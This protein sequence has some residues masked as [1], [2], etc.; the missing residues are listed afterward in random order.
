MN[1][2]QWGIAISLAVAVFFT[3]VSCWALLLFRDLFQRLHYLSVVTTVSML[4]LLVAVVI[5]E[6]AG[7]AAIKVILT[8]IVLLLINA[9]LTHATARAARVRKL[10]HWAATPEEHIEGAPGGK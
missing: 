10:G 7:Q 3:A 8:F 1:V 4:G 9:V 2:A 6:G 5:K